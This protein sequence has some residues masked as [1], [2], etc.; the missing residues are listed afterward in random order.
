MHKKS[1]IYFWHHSLDFLNCKFMFCQAKN[2][3]N[4]RVNKEQMAID[5][6]I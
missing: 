4:F 5:S 3:N 1:F 2:F 6:S